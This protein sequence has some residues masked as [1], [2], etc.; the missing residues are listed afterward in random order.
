MVM[1]VPVRPRSAARRRRAA[2]Y[3]LLAGVL[4]RINHVACLVFGRID[5]DE[6]VRT[7]ELRDVVVADMPE[8]SHQ[9]ARLFPFA[10]RTEFHVADHGLEI[11]GMDIRA[12]LGAIETFGCL[13]RLAENLQ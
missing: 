2:L 10:A 6:L 13:D 7:L 12:E 11:R 5:P 8:L 9:D 3:Q 1:G 4:E